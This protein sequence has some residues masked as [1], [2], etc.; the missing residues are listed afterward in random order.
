MINSCKYFCL[1]ITIIDKNDNVP[2][3]VRDPKWINIVET[4]RLGEPIGK[5]TTY[6]HM[7]AYATMVL[8]PSL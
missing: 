2:T 7:G 1:Q 6:E 5:Y 4:T 3:F 8:V